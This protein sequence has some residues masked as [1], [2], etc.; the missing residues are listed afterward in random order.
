VPFPR[1]TFPFFLN[2]AR[3][4]TTFQSVRSEAASPPL[5]KEPPAFVIEEIRQD[6]CAIGGLGY[7][8]HGTAHSSD[9]GYSRSRLPLRQAA[10]VSI[11]G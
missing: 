9:G 2:C 5:S 3:H 7:K 10:V 4:D 1:S 11:S 8:H 6:P